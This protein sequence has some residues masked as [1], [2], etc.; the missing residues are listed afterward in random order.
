MRNNT[1]MGEHKGK[2]RDG[3]TT[4]N[5]GAGSG[6]EAEMRNDTNMGER[7]ERGEMETQRAMRE[8]EAR[9]KRRCGTIRTWGNG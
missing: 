5:E 2:G 8:R 1:N 7:M 6:R 3:D 9:E 4:G